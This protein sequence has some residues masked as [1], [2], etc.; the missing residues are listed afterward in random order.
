MET[1]AELDKAK[2][3]EIIRAYR[4]ILMDEMESRNQQQERS[5]QSELDAY[6]QEF[7]FWLWRKFGHFDG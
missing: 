7:V 2:V 1:K 4:I 3:A 5:Q 6:E